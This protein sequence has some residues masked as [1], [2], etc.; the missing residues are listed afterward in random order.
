MHRMK[1]RSP[2]VSYL[3]ALRA[4]AAP[5]LHVL[6]GVIAFVPLRA[7]GDSDARQSIIWALSRLGAKVAPRISK[8]C[9]HV[10][11][12]KTPNPTENQAQVE[13]WVLRD[14]FEKIDKVRPFR[15][16]HMNWGGG[17]AVALDQFYHSESFSGWAA[18]L[19]NVVANGTR[20]VAWEPFAMFVHR[21]ARSWCLVR[22]GFLPLC[23]E[24]HL[25][26]LQIETSHTIKGSESKQM[27]SMQSLRGSSAL[28]ASRL[29]SLLRSETVLFVVRSTKT[30]SL[31]SCLSRG[32]PNPSDKA[33]GRR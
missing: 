30:R 28:P 15:G 19:E 25:V 14:L 12:N 1:D 4:P 20:P 27:E 22:E 6:K 21:L 3:R 11:F 2:S 9:T 23:L 10:V 33:E 31:H 7:D 8:A 29:P 18:A 5:A 17:V 26:L 16:S 13:K 32:Y 24:A